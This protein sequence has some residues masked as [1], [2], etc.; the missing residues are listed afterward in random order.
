LR[1]LRVRN[2]YSQQQ[3]AEKLFVDRSSIANWETGRRVP[4][5]MLIANIAE[6]LGVD[7]R[8]LLTSYDPNEK[9]NVIM[10]DDEKIILAGGLPVLEE[11][12][13]NAAVRGFSK[14]SEALEF[15]KSNRVALAFLDISMG[16][17]SGIDLCKELLKI[18]S[19]TNVI[20]LTAYVDYAFDAWSTG[21]SGFMLKPITAEEVKKN[22]AML[23]YPIMGG[24][25]AW[26]K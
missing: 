17:V 21:A 14:P 11:V 2:G 18:N 19:K 22:L 3:L 9:P 23:R 12:M 7:A 26:E 15:A 5:A 24:D 13:P 25:E 8:V 16:R 20:F 1:R 10:V 4:D 6:C